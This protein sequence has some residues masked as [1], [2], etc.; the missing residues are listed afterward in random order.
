MG[1]SHFAK[2]KETRFCKI[3]LSDITLDLFLLLTIQNKTIYYIL[4]L[5]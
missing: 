3:E 1:K 5:R 2:T 4:H